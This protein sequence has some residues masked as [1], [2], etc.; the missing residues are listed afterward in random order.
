MTYQPR[1][2]VAQNLGYVQVLRLNKLLQESNLLRNLHVGRRVL[3]GGPKRAVEQF[4]HDEFLDALNTQ[5][6]PIDENGGV[7]ANETREPR[8]QRGL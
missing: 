5:A 3:R 6:E 8:R 2:L 7:H 1:R 4:G